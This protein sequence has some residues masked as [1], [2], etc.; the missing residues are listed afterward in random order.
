M[1]ISMR[2]TSVGEQV[3]EEMKRTCAHRVSTMPT[4]KID[5]V[6]KPLEQSHT[7][8]EFHSIMQ[9]GSVHCQVRRLTSSRSATQESSPVPFSLPFLSFCF[10]D[11]ELLPCSRL[12]E[13]NGFS[14]QGSVTVLREHATDLW[15]SEMSGTII[16]ISNEPYQPRDIIIAIIS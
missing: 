10:V 3:Q 5:G 16:G 14:L 15:D 9:S 11:R 4:R 7:S 1:N 8:V 6:T 13:W 2:T 12:R